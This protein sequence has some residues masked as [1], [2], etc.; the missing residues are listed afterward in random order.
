MRQ[1]E[2]RG[3]KLEEIDSLSERNRYVFE[4]SKKIK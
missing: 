3:S 1:A 2:R 4:D